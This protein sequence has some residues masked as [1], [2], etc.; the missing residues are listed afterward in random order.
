MYQ[1]FKMNN[2]VHKTILHTQSFLTNKRPW[3]RGFNIYRIIDLSLSP[4]TLRTCL[5]PNNSNDD[6]VRMPYNLFTI[7]ISG[8]NIKT[9]QLIWFKVY[10]TERVI[11]PLLQKNAWKRCLILIES[12]IEL[13]VWDKH[14]VSWSPSRMQ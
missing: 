12:Y 6:N 3:G 14:Y 9:C 11:L 5:N 10:C 8:L 7:T 1:F 4:L 2:K 13:L